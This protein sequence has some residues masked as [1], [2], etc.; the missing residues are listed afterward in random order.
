MHETPTDKNHKNEVWF[1]Y[2]GEC[3]ICSQTARFYRIKEA[4]GNLHILDARIAQDHPLIQEINHLGFDLDKGMVIKFQNTLYHGS[5]AL[6]VM[7]L[8]GTNSDLFNRLNSYI[9]R[10]KFL[11]KLCYPLLRIARNFALRCKNVEQIKN[12]KMS[13]K[14]LL[15]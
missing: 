4:T 7:A 15:P 6:H 12:L 10:S 1:V 3:P 8:L 13:E 9:F 5:D 11:S 14:I 2:D